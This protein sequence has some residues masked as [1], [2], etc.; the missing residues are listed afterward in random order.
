MAADAPA[1]EDER[2]ET[3]ITAQQGVLRHH[4]TNQSEHV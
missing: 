3:D 4:V 1:P 2:A